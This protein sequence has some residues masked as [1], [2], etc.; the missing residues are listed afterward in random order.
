M[1]LPIGTLGKLFGMS[2]EETAGLKTLFDAGGNYPQLVRELIKGK[3]VGPQLEP[4]IR[5]LADGRE[6]RM[7]ATRNPAKPEQV[8][9]QF[10]SRSTEA[11]EVWEEAQA[12][13]VVTT[14]HHQAEEAQILSA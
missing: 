14:V 5:M 11:G 8:S 6:L 3:L 13:R 2:K 7:T 9:V 12:F 4:L 1:K 10:W